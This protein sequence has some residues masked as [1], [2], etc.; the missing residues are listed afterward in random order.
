MRMPPNHAWPRRSATLTHVITGVFAGL[1]AL[2]SS[3]VGGTNAPTQ[4]IDKADVRHLFGTSQQQWSLKVRHAAASGLAIPLGRAGT[5]SVGLT[6]PASHGIVSTV[7]RYDIG[8]DR[9]SAVLLVLKYS[10]ERTAFHSHVA[11]RIVAIVKRQMA[12]EFNVFGYTE[13]ESDRVAFFFVITQSP[14]AP[15]RR[16]LAT[17]TP[18]PLR[19]RPPTK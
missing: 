17:D 16:D 4:L 10:S 19:S 8:D 6:V 15:R 7:L 1:M 11:D 12:P 14:T 5:R 9:P 3:A 18:T 13:L 2:P